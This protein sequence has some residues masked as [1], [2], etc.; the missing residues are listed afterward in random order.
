MPNYC[1][2]STIPG[3]GASFQTYIHDV[4]RYRFN[5]HNEYELSMILKGSAEFCIEGRTYMLETDDIIM[6][7]ANQGHA[8]L[9]TSPESIALVLRFDPSVFSSFLGNESNPFFQC[10][11]E[12][13]TRDSSEFR[14]LRSYLSGILLSLS[15]SSLPA[16]YSA[17]GYFFLL[18]SKLYDS[19]QAPSDQFLNTGH[20]SHS[21]T[22]RTII[23]YVEKN[24][25]SK[26]TLSEI[27]D[28]VQYNRTYISTFFRSNVGINF[29]EHL[30]RV[31]LRH[32]LHELNMTDKT[33]TTIAH[34]SGFPDLKSFNQFFYRYFQKYPRE[35]REQM[36]ADHTVLEY[37]NQRTY[38]NPRTSDNRSKLESYLQ[39]ATAS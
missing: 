7:N 29:Y 31:R 15:G 9:S 8:S 32:A 24:F 20:L 14:Q 26:I 19:F 5:W 34:E 30:T 4:N 2:K 16:D 22:I 25:T 38:L 33:M 28:L 27:A 3:I 11:S 35:Y 1:Y 18:I 17:W 23:D 12:K 21:K 13:E 36:S 6:I 37:E 39:L 10:R